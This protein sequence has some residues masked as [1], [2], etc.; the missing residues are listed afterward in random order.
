MSDSLDRGLMLAWKGRGCLDIISRDLNQT[1]HTTYLITPGAYF[2]E[3][4]IAFPC[5]SR[6][7]CISKQVSIDPAVSQ[8]ESRAMYRPGLAEFSL[9]YFV[10]CVYTKYRVPNAPAITEGYLGVS[11]R[12][13]KCPIR[14]EVA[15]RVEGPGV[16]IGN[17]IVQNCPKSQSKISIRI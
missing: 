8:T 12:G 16:G 4:S 7:F 10:E 14:F 2:P 11:D 3:G 9:V 6:G 17:L 13:I 5:T 15:V 1:Q